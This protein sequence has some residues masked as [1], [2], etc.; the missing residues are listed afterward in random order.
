MQLP[1]GQFRTRRSFPIS[2]HL[3]TGRTAI[4]ILVLAAIALLTPVAEIKQTIYNTVNVV[5]DK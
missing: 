4:A 1:F 5:P 3:H 2:G